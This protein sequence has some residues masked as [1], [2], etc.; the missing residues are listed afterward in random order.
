MLDPSDFRVLDELTLD[1][2]SQ[3]S[4]QR[5]L[6]SK[7]RNYP[8]VSDGK[9][10]YAIVMTVEKRERSIKEENKDKADSLGDKK[11]LEREKRAKEKKEAKEAKAKE[12]AEKKKENGE[13]KKEKSGVEKKT[14]K[15]LEKLHKL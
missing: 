7:N 15:I 4:Q 9:H 2:A 6:L 5:E 8:L 11:Q 14:N 3:F 12:K 10:L 13:D 1:L